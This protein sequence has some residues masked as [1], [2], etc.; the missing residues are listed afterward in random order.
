MPRV[1]AVLEVPSRD[2]FDALVRAFTDLTSR[3]ANLE[4]R[5]LLTEQQQADLL[6][7]VDES[8]ATIK[9][10]SD[11]YVSV[12]TSLTAVQAQLDALNVPAPAIDDAI[13]KLDA[14]QSAAAA[15]L[16]GDTQPAPAPEAT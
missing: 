15:L 4:K 10:L 9:A 3:V 14:A 11:A 6:R 13:A 5:M 1:L 8:L 16:A 7:E 12:K 2:D